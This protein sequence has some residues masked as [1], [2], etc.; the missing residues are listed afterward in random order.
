MVSALANVPSA[1]A[2]ALNVNND[3]FTFILPFSSLHLA[4][5][6]QRLY[7]GKNTWRQLL[8]FL[9]PRLSLAALERRRT[10]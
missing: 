2:D 8:T 5:C 10:E 1:M 3:V 6:S 9:L 4:W 7:G